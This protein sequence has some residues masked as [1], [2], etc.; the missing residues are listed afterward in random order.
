MRLVGDSN[1]GAA[2]PRAAKKTIHPMRIAIIGT[3]ISGL[4]AAHHLH[5]DH[6]LTLFEAGDHIGGHTHTHDI[7]LAGERHAIDTGFIVFNESNYPHFC[8]LI[9]ELGVASQPTSMSFSVRCDAS[10][11]EYNGSSLNQLFAQRSNLL[12]P[13]FLRMLRDIMRFNREAASLL[14]TTPAAGHVIAAADGD[15]ITVEDFVREHRYSAMFLEKYLIPLGASLWSCPPD[16]F[17]SFPIRFV[18]EFLKNHAMLQYAGR[19]IWRTIAGGSSRYVEPLVRPFRERIHLRTPVV[20][21]RRLAD[22]V[23]ITTVSA[24]TDVRPSRQE[25][26]GFDHVILACHADTALVLLSDASPLERE[27]LGAFPYQRNRAILHTDERVLPRS[28]RAWAS[29]NY[30]IPAV[31]TGQVAVTYHMNTLQNLTSKHQFCVTLNH[32]QGIDPARVLRTIDYH[33]PI[34]TTQRAAAQ[35]RH[36]QM[37]NVNRTSYCGAYWGYG[38]HEDGVCSG[39]RV[40][41]ALKATTTQVAALSP[42]IR[43]DHAPVGVG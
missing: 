37:L 33:H 39:M 43:L 20:Q 15:L 3:G 19:P 24:A 31:D 41:N 42:A 4:V 6:E 26:S 35:G 1:K 21:V 14:E 28:R 8:N 18:I 29:W 23:R 12:R 17:R 38:F 22:E 25:E 9:R 40:A 13:R 27:L 30:R 2:K 32:V 34:Y 16:V 36:H 5:R 11:L 7:Q 10:G